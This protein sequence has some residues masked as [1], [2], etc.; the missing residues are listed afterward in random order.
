MGRIHPRGGKPKRIGGWS[1]EKVQSVAK[2]LDE[3]EAHPGWEAIQE[4]VDGQ[5]TN[6]EADL[7]YGN[8][9]L[10]HAQ[11]ARITGQI[12]GLRALK[13]SA[14]QIR[15]EAADI[16]RVNREAAERQTAAEGGG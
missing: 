6:L 2:L 12:R 10:E 9:P 8:K 16:D 15:R 3:L 4:L 7:L 5:V 14:A 13:T 1:D 11:Y